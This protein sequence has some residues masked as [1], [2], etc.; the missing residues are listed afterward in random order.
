M[1]TKLSYKAESDIKLLH[2]IKLCEGEF[3]T[4]YSRLDLVVVI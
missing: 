1:A 2:T 4:Q 3:T